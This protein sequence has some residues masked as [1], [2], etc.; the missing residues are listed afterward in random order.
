MRKVKPLTGQVLIEI[1]PAEKKTPGGIELP[2]RSLSAEEVQETH[3][4]PEKPKALTGI[5]RACGPWPKLKCGLTLM[6][7]FG[8]NSKVVISPNSGQLLQW[9]TARR[10]KLISQSQV[11]AVLTDSVQVRT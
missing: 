7:E 10:L 2:Q 1:L 4:N 5:V 8:I 11:L 3:Q 9:E 6:P